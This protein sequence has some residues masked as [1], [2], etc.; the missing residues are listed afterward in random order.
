[1]KKRFWEINKKNIEVTGSDKD[2]LALRKISIQRRLWDKMCLKVDNPKQNGSGNIN[3][4]TR[5]FADV[6]TLSTILNFN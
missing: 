1:M 6:K 5:T 3:T 4:T 2:Y